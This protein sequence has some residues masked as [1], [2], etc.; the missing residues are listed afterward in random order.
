MFFERPMAVPKRKAYIYKAI[1]LLFSKDFWIGF[2]KGIFYVVGT[3]I[4]IATFW[5]AMWIFG[6]DELKQR[7]SPDNHIK[8]NDTYQKTYNLSD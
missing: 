2:F 3:F 6:E 1:D 8:N 4:M 5:L 7:K